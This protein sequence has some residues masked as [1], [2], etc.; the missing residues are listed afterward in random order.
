MKLT[1]NNIGYMLV[2]IAKPCK[3]DHRIFAGGIGVK[4]QSTGYMCMFLLKGYCTKTIQ[5]TIQSCIVNT[6]CPNLTIWAIQ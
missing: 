1:I 4:T 3:N 5:L 2:G 6:L